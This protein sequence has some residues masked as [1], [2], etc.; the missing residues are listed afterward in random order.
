MSSHRAPK[1]RR[2]P[3]RRSGRTR[4]IISL[5]A[6]AVLATGM[7]VKGTFAF[8]TDAATASTGSF[9]SG[10]LDISVNGALAQQNGG[11]TALTAFK[12]DT[13]VPGESVAF[14]FPVKNEGTVPFTYK[15]TGTGSGALAVANGLQYAVYFGSA[16][17]NTGTAAAGTRAG[18]CGTATA[19][20]SNTTPLTSTSATLTNADRTLAPTATETVCVIARLNFNAGND[21]QGKSGS[22][23]LVLDSKQ[24]GA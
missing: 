1:T 12:M 21:L 24:V 7:S 23:T 6:I 2:A 16:A 19:T 10:T 9:T 5:G 8:W 3:R 20:D 11:T 17:T 22:A 14:S 4:A 18:A 15:V 13:M